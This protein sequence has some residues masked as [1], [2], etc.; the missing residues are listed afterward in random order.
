MRSKH[1]SA[2]IWWIWMMKMCKEMCA[3]AHHV[4]RCSRAVSAGS[5]SRGGSRQLARSQQ[6]SDSGSRPLSIFTLNLRSCN[7]ALTSQVRKHHARVSPS[8]VL[9]SNTLG[10]H[11]CGCVS[12]RARRLRLQL[13]QLASSVG[14][15][16]TRSSESACKEVARRRSSLLPTRQY[17]SVQPKRLSAR[18]AFYCLVPRG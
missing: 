12:V 8:L 15:A 5:P 17:G 9:G 11:A 18:A 16:G 10:K 14:C 7:T 2:R 6:R 3:R 13:L 1:H 4:Q